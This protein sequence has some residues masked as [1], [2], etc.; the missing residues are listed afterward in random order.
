MHPYCI[1]L[2][3]GYF[4]LLI[5]NSFFW[6][7]KSFMIDISQHITHRNLEKKTRLLSF[8]QYY[9]CTKKTQITSVL[10]V[11]YLPKKTKPDC[12]ITW[13]LTCSCR[14]SAIASSTIVSSSASGGMST[15]GLKLPSLCSRA[16]SGWLAPPS[17]GSKTIGSLLSYEINY[18]NLDVWM[19]LY[20]KSYRKK[21]KC[22]QNQMRSCFP[23]II[24]CY[25]VP[26]VPKY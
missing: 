16:S 17:A 14:L 24:S 18:S 4:I 7:H 12:F 13:Q 11:F 9:I 23:L 6:R 8:K 21:I 26:Y 10:T 22:Y 19:C 2:F 25:Y 15:T 1:T 5:Y 20:Q 3:C